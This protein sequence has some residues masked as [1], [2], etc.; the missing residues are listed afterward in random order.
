MGTKKIYAVE[1]MMHDGVLVLPGEYVDVDENDAGSIIASGRGT[2][3]V[4]AG[5]VAKKQYASAQKN[6]SESVSAVA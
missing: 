5:K 2:Q 6:T 1:P 4:E 3:D